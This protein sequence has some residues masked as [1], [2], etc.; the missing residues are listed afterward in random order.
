MPG[1]EREKGRNTGKF[2]T[3]ELVSKTKVQHDLSICTKYF[4]RLQCSICF[5]PSTSAET[6]P[7]GNTV[8]I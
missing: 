6:K 8:K 1:W 5:W 2:N 3:A 4:P 7:W